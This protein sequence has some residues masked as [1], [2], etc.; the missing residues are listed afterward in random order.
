[1]T[2]LT[3]TELD[4]VAAAI[5][6][7]EKKTDAELVTVL[8]RQAD[9]YHYIPTLWAAL[10]ALVSPG[11]VSLMPFWLDL[12]ETMVVQISVFV[13]LALLLRVPPVLRRIIPARVR[14]WRA[15]N[16]ARRQFL[17][18]NLHHTSGETGILIFVAETERYVEI[19]ADRGISAHVS[20]EAWQD[21]VDGFTAE[22]KAGNTLTGFLDAIAACGIIL[23]QH[24]PATHDRDELPNHLVVI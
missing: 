7:V 3:Q 8:A 4:Q 19:I 16:L 15:S 14:Q 13:V 21:I 9:D 20:N 10:V 23:E 2:L 12:T 22:V 17:E 11:L 18:N 1:M 6:A 24:C 5:A